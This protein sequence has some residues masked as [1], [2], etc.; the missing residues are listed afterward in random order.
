MDRQW[1][2]M[3][4]KNQKDGKAPERKDDGDTYYPVVYILWH[5]VRGLES[6]AFLERFV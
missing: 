6:H 4:E 5:Y 2:K 1:K 3:D